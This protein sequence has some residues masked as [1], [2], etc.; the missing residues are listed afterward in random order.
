MRVQLD[1]H[2]FAPRP[3]E[4]MANLI[5]PVDWGGSYQL[6][7]MADFVEKLR[8]SLKGLTWRFRAVGDA[9]LEGSVQIVSRKK[10]KSAYVL[11]EKR[12]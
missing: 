10:R 8:I 4:G 5:V 1:V 2:G 6:A 12:N 11:N 3:Q 9:M 7:L